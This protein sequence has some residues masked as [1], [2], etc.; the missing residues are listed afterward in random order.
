MEQKLKEHKKDTIRAA[1][2]AD[3]SRILEALANRPVLFPA[4]KSSAGDRIAKELTKALRKTNN[5][6][7]PT[8]LARK[9]LRKYAEA[10]TVKSI[11]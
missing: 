2:I 10:V 9:L 8:Q 6:I 11:D 4:R 1:A 7:E 5:D 3:G